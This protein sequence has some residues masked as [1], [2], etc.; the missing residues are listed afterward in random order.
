MPQA[1]TPLQLDG[2]GICYLLQLEDGSEWRYLV[3]IH[4]P[5]QASVHNQ[6]SHP[7]WT[8]L[9]FQQCD[10][11]P[12]QES[13]VVYCPAALD[14]AGIAQHFANTASIARADVWVYTRQRSYF[15][16][17][18]MQNILRSLFGLLMAS[19]ACPVLSRLK[20]LAEFHLPFATLQE[21]VH[22]MAGTYLIRQYQKKQDGEGEPDWQLTGLQA[23][24]R[25]LK[26]VNLALMRRLRQASRD[27]ANINAIQGFISI[28]SIVEM[29][30]D[31]IIN[32]MSV[33]L[34]Q[35]M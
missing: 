31:D 32:K 13:E 3:D 14:F 24:Y 22:R 9:G 33:T 6:E 18:D 15:K 12:Y 5:Q 21:T 29:G 30:V 26:T 19:G 7:D 20:P 23:L 17:C 1:P 34:R 35:G 27:D 11:C 4:R 8:R 10:N 2:D 16:N 28:S 25:E